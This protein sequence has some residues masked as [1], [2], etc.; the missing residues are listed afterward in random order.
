DAL[1][2]EYEP[3]LTR[4]RLEPLLADLRERLVPLVGRA[5]AAMA[6]FKNPLEGNHF[7]PGAQWKLSDRLLHTVGFDFARGRLDAT[8]H[9]FTSMNGADDIRVTTRIHEDD[10]TVNM[11][12]TLHEAGHALYDL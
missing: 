9:P 10:F 6:S 5:E 12:S 7:P 11:L 2:D 8:I 3:G 1:L 4:S